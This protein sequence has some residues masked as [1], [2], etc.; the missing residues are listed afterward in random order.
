[1]RR[2][3]ALLG[4]VL[5]LSVSADGWLHDH[6]LDGGTTTCVA[7]HARQV[8]EPPAAATGAAEPAPPDLVETSRPCVLLGSGR[9]IYRL[10]P[11][12]SPPAASDLRS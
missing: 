2:W 11:K 8:V 5:I 4:V 7:C 9:T 3:L 10:A 6:G 12:A 1:M